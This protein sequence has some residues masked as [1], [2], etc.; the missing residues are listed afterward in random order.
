M[1]K[2]YLSLRQRFEETGGRIIG[3]VRSFMLAHTRL[4]GETPPPKHRSNLDYHPP[5]LQTLRN[6]KA[7]G[8]YGKT[9]P[10]R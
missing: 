10:T 8:E 4:V 1:R 6:R 2:G 3:C 9:P 5:A 7:E